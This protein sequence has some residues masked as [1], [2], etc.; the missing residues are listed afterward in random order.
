MSRASSRMQRAASAGSEARRR[1]AALELAQLTLAI[2]ADNAGLCDRVVLGPVGTQPLDRLGA[3]A[4]EPAALQLEHP[5][6]P[7]QFRLLGGAELRSLGAH[8]VGD[9][10]RVTGVGLPW[11]ASVALA[12]RAP[13][14]D[15][16]HLEAGRSEGGDQAASIAAGALDSDHGGY[17]VVIDQPVNQA[18]V[19]LRGVG[20]DQGR[21]SPRRASS[22]SAAAWVCL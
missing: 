1:A 17:C 19:A 10:D 16:Q 6:C 12:V 8:D 7:D 15:L 3:V 22:I 9:R 5:E 4:H 18:A 20:D 13:R 2:A 11:P 14:R 21:R